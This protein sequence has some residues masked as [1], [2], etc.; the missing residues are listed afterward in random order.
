MKKRISLSKLSIGSKLS[1]ISEVLTSPVSPTS[2]PASVGLKLLKSIVNENGNQSPSSV[3]MQAISRVTFGSQ[4]NMFDLLDIFLNKLSSNSPFVLLKALT[5]LI[6]TFK[7]GSDEFYRIFTN[8][9]R[10]KWKV[11]SMLNY[12]SGGEISESV[13]AKARELDMFCENPEYLEAKKDEFRKLRTSFSQ[14][15]PRSSFDTNMGSFSCE[16][17][18]SQSNELSSPT[19]E[20]ILKELQLEDDTPKPVKET[21]QGRLRRLTNINEEDE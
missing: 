10:G 6:F 12:G 2:D 14:P 18:K 19:R 17:R 5:V 4:R 21:W 13:R 9:R 7:T 1:Q 8:N 20:S 15:T 3:D 16:S 11:K